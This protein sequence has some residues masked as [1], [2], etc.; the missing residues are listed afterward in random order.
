MKI[1]RLLS[2]YF[3]SIPPIYFYCIFSNV[4]AEEE[5]VDIWKIEK[6]ENIV[7]NSTE[8]EN[9]TEDETNLI[10]NTI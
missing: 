1:L 4:L 8:I 6:T 3:L 9:I 5:P 10:I 2:R 7:E